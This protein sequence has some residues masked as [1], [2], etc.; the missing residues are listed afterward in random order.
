MR[1]TLRVCFK[2]SLSLN[3]LRNFLG[4]D[5]VFFRNPMRDNRRNP[6][7]KEVKDPIVH[8]LKSDTEFINS[9]PEQVGFGSSEFVAELSEPFKSG[10]C[11]CPA[12]SPEESQA[13]P[14]WE[15]RA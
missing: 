14:K 4:R 8:V 9:V 5:L 13:S 3:C 15:R 1:V 10:R 12:P 6:A 11:I 2:L 7:V